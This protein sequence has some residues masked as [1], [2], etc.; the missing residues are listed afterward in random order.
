MSGVMTDRRTATIWRFAEHE[1]RFVA[2]SPG[3][4]R[5]LDR[6]AHDGIHRR[7]TRPKR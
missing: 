4:A 5:R 3:C 6:H 1:R 7:R 2:E